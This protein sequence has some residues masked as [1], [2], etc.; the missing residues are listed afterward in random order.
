MRLLSG[1]PFRTVVM[2]ASDLASAHCHFHHISPW[3]FVSRRPHFHM[4]KS[5]CC[6]SHHNRLLH[7]LFLGPLSGGPLAW[8]LGFPKDG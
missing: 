2:K 5:I 3:V 7:K 6:L 1:P 4:L 8:P